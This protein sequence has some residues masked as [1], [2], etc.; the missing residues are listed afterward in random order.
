M[1]QNIVIRFIGCLL[2]VLPHSAHSSLNSWSEQLSEFYK[3][4]YVCSESTVESYRFKQKLATV[5]LSVEPRT[6]TALKSLPK[7][8][9]NNWLALHCPPEYPYFYK[10]EGTVDVKLQVHQ[11]GNASME[12]SCGEYY[13]S[14]AQEVQKRKRA[15]LK[16][17]SLRLQSLETTESN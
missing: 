13:S 1:L 9:R 3:T 10:Q 12:I 8:E 5:I 11:A 2:V 14:R 15:L 4:M 17:V 16:Q 6:R 7:A